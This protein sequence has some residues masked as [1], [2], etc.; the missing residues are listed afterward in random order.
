VEI[1]DF[2]V[3]FAEPKIDVEKMLAKKDAVIKQLTTGLDG[4]CKARK[5]TRLTGKGFFKDKE[6]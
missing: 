2:G 3:D 1:T 6:T 4:L 5:I